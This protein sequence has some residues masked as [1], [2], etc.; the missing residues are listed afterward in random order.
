ML[1]SFKS[2][3]PKIIGT[4]LPSFNGVTLNGLKIDSGYFKNKVSL[5]TFFYIGCPPCLYEING[6]KKLKKQKDFQVLY[7]VSNTAWEMK[8]FNSD[9]A[10][11][12]SNVR[13]NYQAGKIDYEILPQCEEAK[14]NQPKPL[15]EPDCNRI[16][17]Q[18]MVSVYPTNLLI[19][20]KGI[21]RQVWYGFGMDS[22]NASAKI[23]NWQKE[24]DKLLKQN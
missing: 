13:T 10:N 7:V 20:K 4:K 3:K 12:Y 2:D 19:D 21:I 17:Q 1:F 16:S 11:R 22:V 6:L 9:K 18:L 24:I 15:I 14:S 23:A 8:Q 5:I